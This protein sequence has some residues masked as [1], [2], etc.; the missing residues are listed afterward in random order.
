M[1]IVTSEPI[2]IVGVGGMGCR[3]VRSLMGCLGGH[4]GNVYID[5]DADELKQYRGH[6]TIQ[7]RV[8][9]TKPMLP[10]AANAAAEDAQRHLRHAL[11]GA[12]MVF[13]V[14]A[15][16]G[17][18]GSG[19][20]AVVARVA[21]ELGILTMCAVTF[22]HKENPT[23]PA[24]HANNAANAQYGLASLRQTSVSLI[25]VRDRKR[26]AP[27][28]FCPE[29]SWSEDPNLTLRYEDV[30]CDIKSC[31][32]TF[33]A[34]VVE[35]VVTGFHSSDLEDLRYVMMRRGMA[36]LRVS[37]CGGHRKIE[38]TLWSVALAH[39]IE[40]K[41]KEAKCDFFIIASNEEQFCTRQLVYALNLLRRILGPEAHISYGYVCDPTL[42]SMLR[43]TL[44]AT[45]A[46][47]DQFEC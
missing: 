2:K 28:F 39:D 26:F 31:L 38:N 30:I 45:G 35:M 33:I 18:A 24:H 16:G 41:L 17:V 23:F 8:S 43:M 32:R 37:V 47:D 4:V 22:P 36:M 3:I 29:N 1:L 10:D 19:A 27:D 42:G 40:F 7:L 46:K 5:I 14:S 25:K 11:G 21:H 20:T 34:D 15:L 9:A 44:L 6:P 12:R 13:I